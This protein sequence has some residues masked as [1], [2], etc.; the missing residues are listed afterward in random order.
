[1]ARRTSF[2][3]LPASDVF[4]SLSSEPKLPSP[5][6]SSDFDRDTWRLSSHSGQCLVRVF[7]K[8]RLFAMI[9]LKMSIGSLS[10]SPEC[11]FC[12]SH[13]HAAFS[14]LSV[15]LSAICELSPPRPPF[16]SNVFH[17]FPSSLFI[18]LRLSKDIIFSGIS[19][20]GPFVTLL[21]SGLLTH[22]TI[23]CSEKRSIQQEAGSSPT[24]PDGVRRYPRNPCPERNEIAVEAV[25][26]SS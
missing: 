15:Q 23:S 22:E 21:R 17:S 6:T 8:V 2:A 25:P 10:C 3:S 14:A 11:D 13:F 12:V 19:R 9:C 5:L 18:G 16:S 20:F 26:F 1:M 4:L 7:E 24:V